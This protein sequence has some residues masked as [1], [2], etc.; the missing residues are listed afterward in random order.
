ML[1]DIHTTSS[2]RKSPAA[3][4]ALTS[5]SLPAAAAAAAAYLSLTRDVARSLG[6]SAVSILPFAFAWHFALNTGSNCTRGAH[7]QIRPTYF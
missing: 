1:C 5:L 4:A 7:A 3:A 2:P 6:P